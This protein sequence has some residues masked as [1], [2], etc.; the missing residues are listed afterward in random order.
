VTEKLLALDK[1]APD[2]DDVRYDLLPEAPDFGRMSGERARVIRVNGDNLSGHFGR[3][4]L[5]C[6]PP[7]PNTIPLTSRA[8]RIALTISGDT[9]LVPNSKLVTVE[10]PIPAAF[11]SSVC[12]IFNSARAARHCSG[13]ISMP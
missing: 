3:L 13:V 12:F 7:F 11:A 5:K 9:G 6:A 1:Q 8:I 2:F 4:L 10:T